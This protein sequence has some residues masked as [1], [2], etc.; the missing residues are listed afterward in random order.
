[1]RSGIYRWTR[2]PQ[3]ATI[4]PF[5]AALAIAIGAPWLMVQTGLL[6]A[7]YVLMALNEEPWL[8]ARYGADYDVYTKEV[9]RFFT[10][11]RLAEV[12]LNGSRPFDASRSPRPPR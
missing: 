5:Y 10:F 2:N 3:Y 12:M 6:I 7:I 11:R 8:R 4:I 9:S 1:M